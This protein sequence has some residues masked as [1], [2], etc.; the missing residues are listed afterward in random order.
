MSYVLCRVKKF[1]QTSQN[2][3]KLKFLSEYFC[4]SFGLSVQWFSIPLTKSNLSN[5]QTQIKPYS[6]S[7]CNK[8]FAHSYNVR[9]H[10]KTHSDPNVYRKFKCN[11]CK[12]AFDSK[13]KLNQVSALRL[14]STDSHHF[15]KKS[16]CILFPFA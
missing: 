12:S 13:V 9:P 15:R 1:E 2:S 8:K 11:F 4:S 14:A 6:C 16:S 10:E 5:F 3:C 7:I